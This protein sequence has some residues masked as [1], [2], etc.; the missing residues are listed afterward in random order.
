MHHQVHLSSYNQQVHD[1]T[2]KNIHKHFAPTSGLVKMTSPRFSWRCNR[3]FKMI[4]GCFV[5]APR[6]LEMDLE[7]NPPRLWSSVWVNHLPPIT[8]IASS[9][10]S[11]TVSSDSSVSPNASLIFSSHCSPAFLLFFAKWSAAFFAFN[12]ARFARLRAVHWRALTILLQTLLEFLV[13][14]CLFGL[15]IQIVLSHILAPADVTI[16]MEVSTPSNCTRTHDISQ[17]LGEVLDSIPSFVLGWLLVA[18][19]T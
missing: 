16:N 17:T 13:F 15:T 18:L 14:Y 11:A 5:F 19:R 9:A 6:G 1:I 2:P 7:L 8:K 3:H 4:W 10:S 12:L